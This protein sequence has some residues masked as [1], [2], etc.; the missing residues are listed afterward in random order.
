MSLPFVR[1]FPDGKRV[2]SDVTCL[3][4]VEMLGREFIAAG[5][6]YVCEILLNG[7]ARI[8]A[9]VQIDGD[10][11]DVEVEVCENGPPL[12]AAVDRLVRASWKHIGPEMMAEQAKDYD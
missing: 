4:Q 10:Q 6:R 5:G 8:A 2:L 7:Q 3:P 11:E 12:A 9:C 1:Q